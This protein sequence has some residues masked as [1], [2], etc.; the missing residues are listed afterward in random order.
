M[1]VLARSV[2]GRSDTQIRRM[3]LAVIVNLLTMVVQG[4]N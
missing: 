4:M 2:S 3:A 1:K